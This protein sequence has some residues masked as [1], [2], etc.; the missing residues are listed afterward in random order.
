MLSQGQGEGTRVLDEHL[1][2]F[3]VS[4]PVVPYLAHGNLIWWLAL[5]PTAGGH[6]AGSELTTYVFL[7]LPF[8]YLKP[9][10]LWEGFSD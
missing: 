6:P 3:H 4:H 9:R 1:M 10:A 2:A 5:L 7:D 8:H